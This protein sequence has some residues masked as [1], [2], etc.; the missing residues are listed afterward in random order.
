MQVKSGDRQVLDHV[1]L[2]GDKQTLLVSTANVTTYSRVYV[3]GSY[4]EAGPT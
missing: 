4:L 3:T 2:L 1:R